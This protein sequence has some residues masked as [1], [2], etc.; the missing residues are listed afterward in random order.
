MQNLSTFTTI[1]RWLRK[2]LYP[3]IFCRQTFRTI[4]LELSS[5][6]RVQYVS[7]KNHWSASICWMSRPENFQSWQLMLNMN[8]P[9]VAFL[10]IS[11]KI[12]KHIWQ[13]T[14]VEGYYNHCFTYIT[15]NKKMTKPTFRPKGRPDKSIICSHSKLEDILEN[16][17]PEGMS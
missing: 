15:D 6:T 2:G 8:S 14:S 11:P 17:R 3:P 9:A 5:S 12:F 4:Y 10:G 13:D 16:K 1:L 7:W